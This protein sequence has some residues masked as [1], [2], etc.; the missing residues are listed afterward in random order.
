MRAIF[1]ITIIICAVISFL[2]MS[3]YACSGNT[4]L[5]SVNRH[6]LEGAHYYHHYKNGVDYKKYNK[7][8]IEEKRS[9]GEKMRERYN[10][11]SDYNRDIDRLNNINIEKSN[12]IK[13]KFRNEK[14]I[15]LDYDHDH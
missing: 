14:N 6:N 8:E 1:K 13:M 5:K 15:H 2:E 12:E 3:P 10:D 11:K 7:P 9:E 4:L